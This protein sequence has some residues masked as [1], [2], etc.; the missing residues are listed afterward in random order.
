MISPAKYALKDGRG[1]TYVFETRY[2]E[3][4]PMKTVLIDSRTSM[5]NRLEDAIQQAIESGHSVFKKMPRIRVTYGDRDNALYQETDLEL[6]HRAFDGHI[7]L[8]M[9]DGK[10]ITE[11]GRYLAARNSSQNNALGLFEISPITVL[12]GGWDSTRGINQAKMPSCIV[13]EIIGLLADQDADDCNDVVTYRS[14]ARCDPIAASFSLGKEERDRILDRTDGEE[15]TKSIRKGLGQNSFKASNL[16][17]GAIPP[18]VDEKQLDGVATQSIIRSYVLSFATL[19]RLHFGKGPE[20]DAAIRALL[21]AMA[22][23][24]MV[25]NDS[26]LYLRANTHLVEKES[27]RMRLDER[28]GNVKECAALSVQEADDLLVEAYEQ[29]EAIAQIG[30]SEDSF[31]EVDG[32]LGI[33]QN[34]SADESE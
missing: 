28:M 1:A 22:I 30:W 4:A 8:G 24:A 11:N 19:R 7:R 27:P 20:A 14:G 9:V 34:A 17:I 31:F 12:L 25:R 18:S 3:G 5:A 21:A 33:L 16:V 10:S 15:L 2:I 23:D 32:D 26:E 6:P 29:A 13:G